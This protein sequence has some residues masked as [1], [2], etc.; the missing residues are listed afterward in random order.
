MDNTVKHG[1]YVISKIR[2]APMWRQYRAEGIPIISSWIDDGDE[3]T[4]DFAEA[5][6]RYFQEAANALNALVY[7]EPGD[8]LKGGVAELG[9]ALVSGVGIIIVGDPTTQFRTL[10]DHPHVWLA[11]S[12]ETVLH[13]FRP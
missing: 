3:T 6:P 12:L 7:L 4:I 10:K 1:L 2:H 13:L 8:V 5:W 9:A 11:P